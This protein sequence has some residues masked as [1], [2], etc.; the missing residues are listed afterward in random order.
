MLAILF[1][2]FISSSTLGML[3]VKYVSFPSIIGLFY[4]DI[5][6]L[7]AA[8]VGSKWSYFSFSFSFPPRGAN[9][10]QTHRYTHT[11]THTHTHS[12]RRARANRSSAEVCQRNRFLLPG[13]YVFVAPAAIYIEVS[14][15]P[16]WSLLTP[17]AARRSPPYALG[18]GG[19]QHVSSS[20]MT[21]ILLLTDHPPTR[22]AG[23]VGSPFNGTLPLSTSL[24]RL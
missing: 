18:W 3:L 9:H 12:R 2:F 14:L 8:H 1:N 5:R 21:C 7:Y 13:E 24:S 16:S 22:W 15:P 6:S 17:L 4:I 11:H 10:T 20:S 23:A 19:W